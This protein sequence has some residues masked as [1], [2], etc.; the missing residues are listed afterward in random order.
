MTIYQQ[1]VVEENYTFMEGD[2]DYQII[3]E[4]GLRQERETWSNVDTCDNLFNFSER[5]LTIDREIV[6]EIHQF[7]PSIYQEVRHQN[8]KFSYKMLLHNEKLAIDTKYDDRSY[9]FTRVVISDGANNAYMDDITLVNDHKFDLKEEI[10]KT[11]TANLNAAKLK[12]TSHFEHVHFDHKSLIFS[13]QA[14][15]YF[16]HEIL[17]HMLESDFYTGFKVISDD[18]K[19]SKKLTVTDGVKGL[20]GIIGLNTYDDM[21]EEIEEVVL[22]CDGKIKNILADKKEDSFDHKLYGVSRRSDYHFTVMPRM[23]GTVIQPFDPLCQEEIIAKYRE[24]IFIEKVY[25]GNVDPATGNYQL[26]GNGLVVCNGELS[27]ERILNLKISGNILED[28]DRFE[29]IGN[30][31][32]VTGSFC[33]KLDQMVRVAS[34]GPTA[35]LVNMNMEGDVYRV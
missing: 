34:G 4:S 24:A 5:S 8:L 11:V 17:G 2:W 3:S 29:Y 7:I 15:G 30:D 22:V 31:V 20:E 16:I 12:S 33:G 18:I 35:S 19:I 21:G 6:K 14:I 13:N 1:S 23:R 25:V 9:G 10:Q 32:N 28:L 26:F 27:S